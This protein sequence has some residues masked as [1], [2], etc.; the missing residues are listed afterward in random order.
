[1]NTSRTLFA[2]LSS[3]GLSLFAALPAWAEPVNGEIVKV[4]ASQQ[5]LTLR[6]EAI[7][8]LDMPAMTMN[9]RLAKPEMLTGL[10]AGDKVIFEAEDRKGSYVVTTIQVKP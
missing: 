1:M 8:S 9:Y 10:K 4:L 3:L 5:K 2:A 6:H 7:P